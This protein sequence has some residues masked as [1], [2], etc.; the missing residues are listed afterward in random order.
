MVLTNLLGSPRI[1]AVLFKKVCSVVVF[2][3]SRS[4]NMYKKIFCRKQII[5]LPLAVCCLFLFACSKGNVRQQSG[6]LP[7]CG[8]IQKETFSSLENAMSALSGDIMCRNTLETGSV[9]IS[10]FSDQDNRNPQTGRL[11][12][13]SFQS[14]IAKKV[15]E[16]KIIPEDNYNEKDYPDATHI[17]GTYRQDKSGNFEITA[18]SE[19]AGRKNI[20]TVKVIPSAMKIPMPEKTV[21]G[22]AAKEADSILTG[23]VKNSCGR[24]FIMPLEDYTSINPKTGVMFRKIITEKNKMRGIGIAYSAYEADCVA[25]GYY[26]RRNVRGRDSFCVYLQVSDKD[27][28]VKNS[29]SS[30]VLAEAVQKFHQKKVN[31]CESKPGPVPGTKPP[32]SQPPSKPKPDFKGKYI[33]VSPLKPKDGSDIKFNNEVVQGQAIKALM[34]EFPKAYISVNHENADIEVSGEYEITGKGTS[35]CKAKVYLKFFDRNK[36][37]SPIKQKT[38]DNVADCSVMD[39]R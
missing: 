6:G 32:V 39:L 14:S 9:A 13:S 8:E 16:V 35:S 20:S 1:F 31:T 11:I 33:Y 28:S 29:A 19:K 30:C 18:Y 37:N 7:V 27:G 38:L 2:W 36:G 5:N 23:D 17:Y 22:F 3:Y 25:Q 21:C 10:E 12:N 4:V 26:D 15:Q 24:I 34:A